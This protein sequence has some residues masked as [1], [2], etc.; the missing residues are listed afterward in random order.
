MNT[1]VTTFSKLSELT[2]LYPFHGTEVAFSFGVLAFFLAFIVWQIV[3]ESKHH[4]V[5][6]G[7]FT[8]SPAE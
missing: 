5:I 7:N 1:G 4:K 6:I 8:A 2:H 3:M